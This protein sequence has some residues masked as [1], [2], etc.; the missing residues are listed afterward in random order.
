M[1]NQTLNRSKHMTLRE[2]DHLRLQIDPA[3]SKGN[4]IK[5]YFFLK[6]KT[7]LCVPFPA[8]VFAV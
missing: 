8:T 7:I 1:G 4:L 3:L 5:K 2:G 6:K